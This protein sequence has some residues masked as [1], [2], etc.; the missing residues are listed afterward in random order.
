MGGFAPRGRFVNLYL[1]GL[2]WGQYGLHERPDS[3]YAAQNFGGNKSEYD[4]IKHQPGRVVDGS[5]AAFS[6]LL[7]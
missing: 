2:Y 6:D 1:N 3:S 5:A 4:S 7:V